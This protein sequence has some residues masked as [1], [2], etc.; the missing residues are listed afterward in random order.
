VPGLWLLAIDSANY[1]NNRQAG[2]PVT[3]SGLTQAREDW[4]EGIL[5]EAAKRKKAV[6]AMMHHGAIEHFKGEAQFYGDYLVTG[7]RE[8]SRMLAAYGVR[9]VFTGHFHSQDIVLER[10]T[11]GR[12]LYDVETGSLVTFPDPMR[13]VEIRP[14]QKMVITSSRITDLPSFTALGEDF[15]AYSKSY[16]EEAVNTIAVKTMTGLGVPEAEAKSL[17]PQITAA[18]EANLQG[19]EHFTGTEMIRTKGLSFM[20]GLVVQSR[21]DLVN[22]L[23]HDLEPPDNNLTIDL[24]DGSW[25]SP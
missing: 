11:P 24:R 9:T 13:L 25:A 10:T 8:F 4:I 1:A 18:I 16:M 20:G 7:W 17:T 14:D 15:G 23:W 3:A 5:V 2:R 6:I 12:F 21:K 22:G 19:D